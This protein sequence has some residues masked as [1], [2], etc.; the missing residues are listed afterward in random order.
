M[1]NNKLTLKRRIYE[2]HR[3]TKQIDNYRRLAVPDEG[4]QFACDPGS[5]LG[6][7]EAG[8]GRKGFY[9]PNLRHNDQTKSVYSGRVCSP[10]TGKKYLLT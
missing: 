4:A 5:F 8:N 10:G 6:V 1:R 7:P 9:P 3:T 2:N